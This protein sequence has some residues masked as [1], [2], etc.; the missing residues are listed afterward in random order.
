M[1]LTADDGVLVAVRD[2]DPAV[3]TITLNR[4][5]R[6]NAVSWPMWQRSRL[7]ARTGFRRSQRL[8]ESSSPSKLTVMVCHWWGQRRSG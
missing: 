3:V 1:D 5:E 7:N 6:K 8:G 2:T 4:P